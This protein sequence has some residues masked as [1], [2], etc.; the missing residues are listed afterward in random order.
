[1][2]ARARLV[3]AATIHHAVEFRLLLRT[4][5][6]AELARRVMALLDGTG[7]RSAKWYKREMAAA[8]VLGRRRTCRIVAAPEPL[9]PPPVEGLCPLF[10]PILAWSD[11]DERLYR[12][13]TTETKRRFVRALR[14]KGPCGHPFCAEYKFHLCHAFNRTYSR[15]PYYRGVY[16]AMTH[17]EGCEG[18]ARC[19]DFVSDP[20]KATPD[21]GGAADG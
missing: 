18:C 7:L 3:Q 21:D 13:P 5:K 4:Y 10:E 2:T 8:C 1:M 14:C 12:P 9:V 16:E 11:S 6:K 17:L 20:C 15:Y 19:A